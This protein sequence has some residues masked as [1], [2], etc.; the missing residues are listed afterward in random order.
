MNNTPRQRGFSLVEL[1]VAL[2]IGSFLII[3]AVTVYVQSRNSYTVNETVARLQ[4]NA[5]FALSTIEPDIRL[6]N[7]WGLMNDPELITG[8][9]DNVPLDSTAT[10][11]DCG[12]GFDID[13]T[14]PIEGV[15]N[16]YDLGCAENAVTS[17]TPGFTRTPDTIVVRHANETTS[18]PEAGRLQLYSTRR[19]PGS[20]VFNSDTAPGLPG[21]LDDV[22]PN[23]PQAEVRNLVVRA[24]YISN[25]SSRAETPSL[26][27]KNLILGPDFQDEEVMPGVEDMQ[28]QFGIDPGVGDLDANGVPDRYTGIATRY[29]NPEDPALANAQIV[30]VRVW[31]LI[32][33]DQPEVGFQNARAFRYA[34]VTYT[35]NDSFRRLL[36]SRTIQ[37]RNTVN[38]QT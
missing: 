18:A 13:L 36:V 15:N 27:R 4:E 38:L 32:R 17:P 20:Q 30:A 31:L 16:D 3:G 21:A 26:R 19:G 9:A 7:Y 22:P 2:T 25:G 12:A 23:G 29:V 35:P 28:V 5:R 10:T 33:A 34:D 6:A 37:I 1:M 14:A 8:T 11:E 24:Y